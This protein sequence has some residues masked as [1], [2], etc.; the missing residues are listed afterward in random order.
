MKTS[1]HYILLLLST[2]I[3]CNA[4]SSIQ[5]N[6]SKIFNRN[7]AT[8]FMTSPTGGADNSEFAERLK[9]IQDDS[10]IVVPS[11]GVVP[12]AKTNSIVKVTEEDYPLNIPSPIL[13]SAS[14]LLAIA[15]T[16][17]IFNF[18]AQENGILRIVGLGLVS[19]PLTLF[20]FYAA[21]KKGAAET[22]EDDRKFE[23]ERNRYG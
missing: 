9:L 23:Q 14:M 10:D 16:G 8:A 13:L 4:F 7:A 5:K 6:H 19:L 21:V 15:S 20:L 1:S 18:S 3:N 12:A 22:E 2:A 17:L 11:D